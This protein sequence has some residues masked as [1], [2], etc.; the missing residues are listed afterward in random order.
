MSVREDV[1]RARDAA[2]DAF[3]QID[4]LVTCAGSSPGGLLEELTED[5]KLT[6]GRARR[7]RSF[8][9]QPFFV[10]SQFTGREGKYVPLKD[11]IRSFG[12]ILDGKHDDLPEDAFYMVGTVDEAVERAKQLSKDERAADVKS[13]AQAEGNPAADGDSAEKAPD[14]APAGD[15][16]A[17]QPAEA[18]GDTTAPAPGEKT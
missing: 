5:Q 12:E 4:I 18:G 15:T 8:L 17:T 7:I 11:T 6:V 2:I 13:G 9:S 14:D 1:E 3:G 10:A 16:S